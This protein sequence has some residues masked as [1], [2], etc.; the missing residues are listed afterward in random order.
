MKERILKN[1]NKLKNGD[2]N[3]TNFQKYLDEAIDYIESTPK[4][5]QEMVDA[6]WLRKAIQE[7][8]YARKCDGLVFSKVCHYLHLYEEKKDA[9]RN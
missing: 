1:L 6:K 7:D 8:I 5:D 3:K 9:M 4:P 2:V